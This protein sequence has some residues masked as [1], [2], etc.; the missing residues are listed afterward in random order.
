M[1]DIN[2]NR[3]C[4]P[5][6]LRTFFPQKST[7]KLAPSKSPGVPLLRCSVRFSNSA[8]WAS[9]TKNLLTLAPPRSTEIS[10]MG[11]Y[12][13]TDD[14]IHSG[15]SGPGNWQGILIKMTLNMRRHLQRHD[16]GLPIAPFPKGQG[17]RSGGGGGLNDIM[18]I[19]KLDSR[20]HGSDDNKKDSGQAGMTE[21]S[22]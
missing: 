1:N 16:I 20:L 18:E 12:G 2:F 10:L 8:L 15:A 17:V 5:E 11:Q 21:R 14:G 13:T 22:A 6:Y 4:A 7:K 19:K 3:G 9:D